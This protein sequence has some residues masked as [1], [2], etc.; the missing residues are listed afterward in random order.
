M[1]S[2]IANAV[3]ISRRLNAAVW[4]VLCKI[5]VSPNCVVQCDAS[6]RFSCP[7]KSTNLITFAVLQFCF[8]S[9]DLLN[10]FINITLI[11]I[12]HCFLNIFLSRTFV[13]VLT[14]LTHVFFNISLTIWFFDQSVQDSKL[15][16]IKMM[17]SVD[18]FLKKNTF[19]AMLHIISTQD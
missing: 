5:Y 1:L 12:Y 16:W 14:W 15:I 2:I 8:C 4:F 13:H 10:I 17:K 9:G 18:V 7:P 3:L 11:L 6:Y 19:N